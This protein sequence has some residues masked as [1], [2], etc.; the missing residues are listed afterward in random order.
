MIKFRIIYTLAPMAK[1]CSLV[2]KETGGPL[3]VNLSLYLWF[4]YILHRTFIQILLKAYN[5]HEIIII[6]IIIILE[7][8]RWSNL[9]N[10]CSIYCSIWQPLPTKSMH[11]EFCNSRRGHHRQN[12]NAFSLTPFYDR[13]EEIIKM[14]YI[15]TMH[16]LHALKGYVPWSK[17]LERQIYVRVFHGHHNHVFIFLFHYWRSKEE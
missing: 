7:F 3:E 15:F 16:P 8:M 17:G 5:A 10:K 2:V 11:S 12:S 13:P 9:E 4:L 6:I 1:L 14:L